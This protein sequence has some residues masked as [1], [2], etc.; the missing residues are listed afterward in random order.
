MKTKKLKHNKKRNTAF[1]YEC[2]VREMT[3]SVLN[4]DKEKTAKIKDCL[5]EFFKKGT[6]L[7]R[8]LDTYKTLY[9]TTN[10]S[11]DNAHR[12]LHEA[13]D[14]N[15]KIDEK[16]LFNEQ[17]RLINFM[18]KELG[19]GIFNYFLPNYK[20]IASISQIFNRDTTVK[21]RVLLENEIV[22]T[23]LKPIQEKKEVVTDNLVFDVFMK[24]FNE[25]YGEDLFEEQKDLIK[26]YLF[27]LDGSNSEV[28]L[29]LEQEMEKIETDLC[30]ME[31]KEINPQV[32]EKISKVKQTLKEAEQI[33]DKMVLKILKIQQLI[34]EFKNV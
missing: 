5:K 33:D 1:L 34:R 19:S 24:K 27:S 26:R 8:Q 20:T 22:K 12:L 28:V 23:M 3:I 25:K 13:K 6:N 16:E 17:T 31:T 10:C 9:N 32:K 21:N 11:L 2:L 18:N 4:K 7:N 29:F 15:Y 14:K 30:L